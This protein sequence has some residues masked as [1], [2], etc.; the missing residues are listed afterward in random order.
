VSAIMVSGGGE[1]E[2]M[3]PTVKTSG[4]SSSTENSSFYGLN[5]A[6]LATR[7][8]K[9]EITG[10]SINT[11]GTGANGLF[12]TG[13]GAS[14]T[15]TSG[16]ITATGGGGHGVMASGGGSL[17]LTNVDIVT[18]SERAAPVATDRG[19]G[20]IVVSGGKMKSAGR[21]SPGIYSTGKITVYDTE[22]VSTGAEAAV[23]EGRNSISLANCTLTGAARCGVMIYQ[24]FSGDAEGREGHFTMTGGSLTATSGPLFFVTNSK[25]VILLKGV[26]ASSASGVLVKAGIDRWGREGSNGGVADFTAD[27]ETL[28]GDMVAEANCSVSAKLQNGTKLTGAVKDAALTLDASSQ[29][30]VT[31]DSTLTSLKDPEG[32]NGDQITNI[33]GNGHEVRYKASLPANEWLKGKTYALAGGGH[34]VPIQ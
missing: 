19:S 25:G 7:S 33:H 16:T 17:A 24:S 3:D 1:L 4:N 20:T 32:V 12:A 11:S 5:A 8:S 14:V 13:A 18:T 21:G 30:N 22:F 29:W 27:D 28:A 6:V 9:I 26:K 23:I 2:L 10:G 31:A 34:L 15:M